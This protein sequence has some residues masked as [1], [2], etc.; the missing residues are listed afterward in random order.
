[1]MTLIEYQSIDER[2]F[3]GM[4]ILQDT[5]EY[6]WPGYIDGVLIG[7]YRTYRDADTALGNILTAGMLITPDVEYA[8]IGW[9]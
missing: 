4:P 3:V 8:P 5:G 2:V 9:A 6:E 7:F 1:M